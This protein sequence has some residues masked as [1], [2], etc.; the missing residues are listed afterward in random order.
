MA[1]TDRRF[2]AV[3]KAARQPVPP[4]PGAATAAPPPAIRRP[5]VAAPARATS[6][7]RRA[8]AHGTIVTA[9]GQ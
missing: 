2:R 3:I 6:I 8:P 1:E 7:I 5:G 4:R 9:T